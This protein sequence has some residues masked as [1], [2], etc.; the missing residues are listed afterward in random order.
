VASG[1]V[2][3]NTGG[4]IAG[5][6]SSGEGITVTF[7]GGV[8]PNGVTSL[9]VSINEYTSPPAPP[10]NNDHVVALPFELT[11][12]DQDGNEVDQFHGQVSVTIDC[13]GGVAPSPNTKFAYYDASA[14]KW[15]NLTVPNPGS[16]PIVGQTTHFTPFEFV[17]LPSP[18]YCSG[19]SAA[20][21]QNDALR[22]TGDLN[23]DGVIDL[24]DFS[25]FAFNYGQAATQATSYSDMNCDGQVD[26]TDFSIFAT[27]YGL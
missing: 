19:P 5:T 20:S 21:A 9:G 8:L 10:P 13:P 14:G 7:P 17:T 15:Q 16:C 11:A 2:D 1:T 12:I 22:G 24:T 18:G 6:L 26:L 27:Y 4:T 23:G 25:I 3:P